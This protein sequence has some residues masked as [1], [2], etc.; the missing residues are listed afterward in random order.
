[1][2]CHGAM[3][4][5]IKSSGEPWSPKNN[6]SNEELIDRITR[7]QKSVAVCPADLSTRSELATLLEQVNKPEEALANWAAILAVDPKDLKVREGLARC[8]QLTTGPASSTAKRDLHMAAVCGPLDRIEEDIIG[9]RWIYVTTSL[10]NEEV[11]RVRVRVGRKT[12]VLRGIQE[13]DFSEIY[14]HEFAEVTYHLIHDG[15]LEADTIYVCPESD[16][17]PD[18]TRKD[19]GGGRGT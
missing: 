5:R 6:R 2:Q 1:M 16:R 9:T 18:R 11:S 14:T 13:I 8:L 3:P 12:G 19:N 7:L 15:I 10:L 4:T 17:R